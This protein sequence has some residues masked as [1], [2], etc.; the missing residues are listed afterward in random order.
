MI[1]ALRGILTDRW[2]RAELRR[3]A[4][5]EGVKLSARMIDQ[6]MGRIRERQ[7]SDGAADKDVVIVAV[8]GGV[9]HGYDGNE[10]FIWGAAIVLICGLSYRVINREFPLRVAA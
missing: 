3:A 8:C 10:P 5:R 9:E 6:L 4:Q 1:E 2:V 7:E